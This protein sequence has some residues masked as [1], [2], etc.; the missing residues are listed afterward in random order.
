M[1]E[2]LENKHKALNAY[3][4]GQIGNILSI[5]GNFDEA[6]KN[7]EAALKTWEEL[8]NA[9]GVLLSCEQIGELLFKQITFLEPQKAKANLIMAL[10]YLNRARVPMFAIKLIINK[11]LRLLEFAFSISIPAK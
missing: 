4:L 11:C 2:H 1:E 8:D 3:L 6:L 9:G 10:K 7:H 5:K